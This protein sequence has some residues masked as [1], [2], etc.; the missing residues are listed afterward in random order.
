MRSRQ[1]ARCHACRRQSRR[2]ASGRNTRAQGNQPLQDAQLLRRGR[3]RLN[4]C[5]LAV[6]ARAAR[7]P[8][9]LTA[10]GGATSLRPTEFEGIVARRKATPLTWASARRWRLTKRPADLS[11]MAERSASDEKQYAHSQQDDRQ[12]KPTDRQA[13]RC[14]RT[15]L[16]SQRHSNSVHAL[17]RKWERCQR[18]GDRCSASEQ[19]EETPEEQAAD[20]AAEDS[21]HE[22]VQRD[23]E[24]ARMQPLGQRVSTRIRSQRAATRRTTATGTLHPKAT[25]AK[26]IRAAK[27]R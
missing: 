16:K 12:E 6:R 14:R 24:F 21:T 17:R 15:A 26:A 5:G 10:T 25:P 7:H 4:R 13:P 11:H 8:R 19:R 3:S 9:R 2:N 23:H 27:A 22:Q 20:D 1:P 18:N